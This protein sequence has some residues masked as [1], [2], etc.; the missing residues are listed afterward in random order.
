MYVIP[1]QNQK[2]ES[3]DPDTAT[4]TKPYCTTE[5]INNTGKALQSTDDRK[6]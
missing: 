6:Q 1:L 2:E 4:Q 3:E 5:A